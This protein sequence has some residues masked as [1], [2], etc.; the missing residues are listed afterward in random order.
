[1]GVICIAQERQPNHCDKLIAYDVVRYHAI[2]P[3]QQLGFIS[4]FLRNDR[5]PITPLFYHSI[6][7]FYFH[8]HNYHFFKYLYN[9]S[10]FIILFYYLYYF[11]YF[12]HFFSEKRY[13]IW[14]KLHCR[15]PQNSQLSILKPKPRSRLRKGGGGGGGTF[16]RR[17]RPTDWHT[18]VYTRFIATKTI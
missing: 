13:H 4:I 2:S 11:Y 16:W 17:E 14:N 12:Y 10:S 6:I 1:M 9:L 5:D 7:L 3:S 18:L 15:S 8:Q